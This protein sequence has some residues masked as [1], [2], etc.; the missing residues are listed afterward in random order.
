MGF[1]QII[2]LAL[3]TSNTA[4]EKEYMHVAVDFSK[5]SLRNFE[6]VA[7]LLN[8]SGDQKAS[9][10]VRLITELQRFRLYTG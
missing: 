8:N 10:I 3:T 6:L 9:F 1:D 7:A 2:Y 4:I 5:P